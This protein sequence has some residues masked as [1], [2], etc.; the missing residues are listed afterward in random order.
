[1]VGRISIAMTTYNSERFVAQQLESFERQV[2]LP[3]ELVVSDDASS[4]STVDV[5]RD[6]AKRAS[7]PV[8]LCV[9]QDNLG[10]SKNFEQAIN[11]CDGDLIFL[12]DSDDYW[13]PRKLEFMEQALNEVKRAGIAVC[14]ADLVNE[15]LEPLGHTS[16]E[17][18]ERFFPDGRLSRQ[19][20]EGNAFHFRMPVRGCCMA[21]RSKFRELVLPLPSG[22]KFQRCGHDYIIVRTIICSGAAGAALLPVPLLAYRRHSG[23]ATHTRAVPLAGR[24][25]SL[26]ASLRE[27]PYL[28]PHLIERIGSESAVRHCR[29]HRLRNSVLRHW[30][31]RVGMPSSFFARAPIVARELASLRYH[32]FSESGLTAL[33]DLLF[34]RQPEAET[35]PDEP[36][37]APAV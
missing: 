29:N 24:I 34:A 17:V 1:M 5:V 19:L 15:R 31:A 27:P 11:K 16:W 32:R 23:Q 33:K 13:Y 12:S 2:R 36:A 22:G 7:F 26:Y 28:L 21:F 3:D 35:Q 10:V 4:D 37:Q 25:S 6:F 18:L 30:R 9:N 8:R 20:A 14:D